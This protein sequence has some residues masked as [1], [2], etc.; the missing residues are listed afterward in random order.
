MKL[1]LF[2][3]GITLS[4]PI[5]ARVGRELPNKNNNNNVFVQPSNCITRDW[6]ES[7]DTLRQNPITGTCTGTNTVSEW[8]TLQSGDCYVLPYYAEGCPGEVCGAITA[9]QDLGLLF[10]TYIETD[11]QKNDAFV[12]GKKVNYL[13]DRDNVSITFHTA[14]DVAIDS[15]TDAGGC[16]TASGAWWADERT[17]GSNSH[18]L[19]ASGG[20]NVVIVN[21]G[22]SQKTV[23][24]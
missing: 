3:T 19:Y 11:S 1:A 10:S 16:D 15:S 6:Y 12:E 24:S 14:E 23:S 21:T 2:L 22:G 13:S 5:Y 9:S 7:T 4:T 18:P 17:C 8:L 20:V